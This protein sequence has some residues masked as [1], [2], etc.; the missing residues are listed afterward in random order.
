MEDVTSKEQKKLMSD[1]MAYLKQLHDID[2]DES[3]LGN[4]VVYNMVCLGVEAIFTSILLGFDCV[5]DHSGILRLLREFEKQ[6]DK[7][8]PQNWI[9]AARLMSS[10][11]SYCSLE[12]VKKIKIPDNDQL[13]QMF[14]F[15][16]EVEAFVEK[17]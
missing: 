6:K 3:K 7:P 15:A 14:A 17:D 16:L 9:E 2:I 5:I 10:F 11:Q 8:L 1:G 13:K 12:V 4:E